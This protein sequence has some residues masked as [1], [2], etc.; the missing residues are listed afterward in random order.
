MWH[1]DE[2]VNLP[3]FIIGA[4]LGQVHDYTAVVVVECWERMM[5][6][7]IASRLAHG[8]L[9]DDARAP[10]PHYD[11]IQIVRP[12]LGTPYTE[13][14][15]LLRTLRHAVAR[16]WADLAFEARGVGVGPQHVP[17]EL[18]IDRT[19]VGVAVSDLL[20]EAGLPHTS[21]TITGGDTITQAEPGHYRV[22]K[23]EL[24][25]RV[26]TTLQQRRLRIAEALSEAR[27]LRA[28]LANFKA[29]ISLG[30]HDSYGA[31]EEWREGSN[32]DTVLA[33]AVAVWYGEHRG[34]D[35]LAPAGPELM[36]HFVGWPT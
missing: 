17:C 8:V 26:Q 30:G 23:R 20:R 12:P 6:S 19:G 2:P 18:V 7:S 15:A 5:A 32:D 31:G 28:E 33:T 24:C 11:V 4:D 9:G 34:G 25:G 21:V 36:R 1:D 22:P 27:V 13:L 16:R 14:P 29:R 10:A 35:V 3:S